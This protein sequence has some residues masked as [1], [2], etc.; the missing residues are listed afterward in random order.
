MINNDCLAQVFWKLKSR[1][2]IYSF[3]SY[4]F[5]LSTGNGLALG[6]IYRA[7]GFKTKCKFYTSELLLKSKS[8][9]Y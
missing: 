1:V 8:I 3:V 6:T 9:S 5:L 7:K 2:C 4:T